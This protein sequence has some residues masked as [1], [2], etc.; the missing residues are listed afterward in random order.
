MATTL[1]EKYGGFAA[2]SKLVMSF[3]DRVLDSDVVGGYFD[4]V[5]VRRVIDH[6]TKFIASLLGG[7]ASYTNESLKQIHQ[8]LKIDRASFTEVSSLLRSSFHL[9]ERRECE[10]KGFGVKQLYSLE[11]GADFERDD[12]DPMAAMI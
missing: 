4:G 2:V 10:V 3:Y 8:H 11:A 12:P 5:D 1:F 9:Q 7:P 6:Q